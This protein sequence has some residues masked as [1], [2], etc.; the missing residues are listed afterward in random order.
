[1]NIQFEEIKDN[2]Y[3]STVLESC[4]ANDLGL[5]FDF[6]GSLI[7]RTVRENY[8]SLLHIYNTDFNGVEIKDFIANDEYAIIGFIKESEYHICSNDF[9]IKTNGFKNTKEEK[10]NII[11]FACAK[12]L[13][14]I[15]DDSLYINV[16]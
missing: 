2:T 3:S 9:Y 13:G 5:D 7:E 8:K 15:V 14:L 6:N 4:I 1:M 16:E 11:N 10:W 12:Y